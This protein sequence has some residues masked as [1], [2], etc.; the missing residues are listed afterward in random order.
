MG[1]EVSPQS[2]I[3]EFTYG[4]EGAA[5]TARLLAQPDELKQCCSVLP[6][7]RKEI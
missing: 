7:M 4:Q 6:T 2:F 3:G 5:R 1:S